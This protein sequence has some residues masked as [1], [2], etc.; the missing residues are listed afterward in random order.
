MTQDR[1]DEV[2]KQTNPFLALILAVAGDRSVFEYKRALSPK[3]TWVL[4]GGS[5]VAQAIAAMLLGPLIAM[6][7]SK[8]MG[9]MMAK[10]NQKDLVVLKE[11]LE[12]GTIV[13]VID[14]RY[15]LSEVAEAIR[16]LEKGHAPGMQL[17]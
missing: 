1:Q 16:Y 7:G 2:M 10:V 8:K 11:L 6:F 15:T 12:A 13:P 14:R 9:F 3:G 5:S 4:I 17:D